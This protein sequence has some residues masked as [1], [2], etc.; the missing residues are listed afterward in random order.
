MKYYT[1]V[2]SRKTPK[3]V[4]DWMWQYARFMAS[5]GY[6]LRSGGAQGADFAFY[7]GCLNVLGEREIYIPWDGFENLKHQPGIGIYSLN[8]LIREAVRDAVEIAKEIHPA[9]DRLS[10]G[11]RK[12]HTRNVFQVLGQDL[13]TPSEV[14]IC[15]TEG[16]KIKGGT[17]TAIN[18]AK[19]YGVGV[20]NLGDKFYHDEFAIRED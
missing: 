8:G 13:K 16:G 6:T 5:I 3:E 2:G 7:M 1:G 11:A 19:K 20:I 9:W 18:L 17:A 14:V 15:W 10:L 12:L 4:C